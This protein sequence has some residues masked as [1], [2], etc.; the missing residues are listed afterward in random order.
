MTSPPLDFSEMDNEETD[1]DVM[2]YTCSLRIDIL[3]IELAS[4][5]K[6]R[7]LLASS[8]SKHIEAA[9]D[10]DEDE[11]FGDKKSVDFS[12]LFDEVERMESEIAEEQNKLQKEL[13][14][15]QANDHGFILNS[16][17]QAAV[18]EIMQA[19]DKRL[20]IVSQHVDVMTEKLERI[21]QEKLEAVEEAKS[22]RAKRIRDKF[23][24]LYLDL[25]RVIDDTQNTDAEIPEYLEKASSLL[26][27]LAD[28]DVD[29]DEKFRVFLAHWNAR[30][31]KSVQALAVYQEQGVLGSLNAMV[32]SFSLSS[33]LA[34]TDEENREL[35][36]RVNECVD[37]AYACLER[38]D[39]LE[40]VDAFHDACDEHWLVREVKN[41]ANALRDRIISTLDEEL[42][43]EEAFESFKDA[44]QSLLGRTDQ[45]RS[46]IQDAELEIHHD[47][48]D[49]ESL[50]LEMVENW[51][52]D[53]HKEITD[54]SSA[55]DEVDEK[56]QAKK[57]ALEQAEKIA[58]LQAIIAKLQEQL[59]RSAEY[60]DNL[61]RQL[62][63][64]RRSV[65][66]SS[67]GAAMMPRMMPIDMSIEVEY[68][69]LVAAAAAVSDAETHS[70]ALRTEIDDLKD[71]LAAAGAELDEVRASPRPDDAALEALK[72][73][74]AELSMHLFESDARGSELQA[75]IG[76]REDDIVRLTREREEALER[77]RVFDEELGRERFAKAEALAEERRLK[78]LADAALAHAAAEA[79]EA[80]GIAAEALAERAAAAAILRAELEAV[81]LRAAEEER[82]R[83]A[84]EAERD[85]IRAEAEEA[86]RAA[87]A[88]AAE[89]RARED[90]AAAR[91]LELEARLADAVA[92]AAEADRIRDEE[93][94][95]AAEAE[96]LRLEAEARAAE[97]RRLRL[98]AEARA[99]AERL[100]RVA[101]E[102]RARL[103]EAAQR[104]AENRALL[105][106]QERDRAIAE[107]ERLRLALAALEAQRRAEAEAAA[108]AAEEARLREEDLKAQN[109]VLEKEKTRLEKI[110]AGFQNMFRIKQG[111][112]V[113]A[114]LNDDPVDADEAKELLLKLSLWELEGKLTERGMI[115]NLDKAL[116]SGGKKF[117]KWS[118][119]EKRLPS[120][121]VDSMRKDWLRK[122]SQKLSI[123]STEGVLG[124]KEISEEVKSFYS[125]IDDTQTLLDDT[126]L[127]V[128]K[129]KSIFASKN[130]PQDLRVNY[131]AKCADQI[132]K[133]DNAN[134][135]WKHR[136]GIMSKE[137]TENRDK[138]KR[139]DN[140]AR[141]DSLLK[142]LLM[143]VE[144]WK[145][146][147]KDSPDDTL[148]NWAKR[149]NL[150]A[151]LLQDFGITIHFD[152]HKDEL[153]EMDRKSFNRKDPA[154]F[155]KLTEQVVHEVEERIATCITADLAKEIYPVFPLAEDKI[156]VRPIHLPN[157][158]TKI[159][160]Y[161]ASTDT[162]VRFV[163]YC[164]DGID[165][166]DPVV[167]KAIKQAKAQLSLELMLSILYRYVDK[168][169]SWP[170]T[171]DNPVYIYPS[172]PES[173]QHLAGALLSLG[174]PY[175]AIKVDLK[176]A[177][178]INLKYHYVERPEYSFSLEHSHIKAVIHDRVKED[179][180]I[181]WNSKTVRK[182]VEDFSGGR[183]KN[184]N[185]EDSLK[186]K[187]KELN[188]FVK[189]KK[190]F[191]HGGVG[192]LKKAAVESKKAVYTPNS[193]R[194]NKIPGH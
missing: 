6:S 102:D 106:E 188:Q 22:N 100:A 191:M 174:V 119:L 113:A 176:D 42:L 135:A 192:A 20:D 88:L 93:R 58:R 73:Q 130:C 128:D 86:A 172:D 27:K 105:A 91:I 173:L 101:A 180:L 140:V 145:E 146:I 81:G 83:L 37:A 72:L 66:W 87:E 11:S 131:E 132:T 57:I 65:E 160:A 159:I 55:L 12:V 103:A 161:A 59:E 165:E 123:D 70:V 120:A 147:T 170:P 19:V 98:E 149:V 18:D 166:N 41:K 183:N 60:T 45:V 127:L 163:P 49:I 94:E 77:A 136:Y 96:R 43:S 23:N 151:V 175:E 185:K 133:W 112:T 125:N 177:K 50:T 144:S 1:E 156:R 164:V 190:D 122:M 76:E 5:K 181:N 24:E 124:L 107:Q 109:A 62:E 111:L 63:E 168:S 48:R 52:V 3:K 121:I 35:T 4:L 108:I 150:Q 99:N 34:N 30:V 115:R 116:G 21:E 47:D 178:G 14:I 141:K 71:R 13:E 51:I 171:A 95:R 40:D 25:Q 7:A 78:D 67:M 9:E 139:L 61:Q 53:W 33:M 104:A 75:R 167:Q 64:Q 68:R 184:P 85:R 2:P 56:V 8:L 26:T 193:P 80:A 152:A 148:A 90:V 143:E 126:A 69:S 54:I 17:E 129:A 82:A 92:R 36:D 97:E 179:T 189:D 154:V 74:V 138:N 38:I 117:M 28:A 46:A 187:R 158:P 84:A 31:N 16:S 182:F 15:V 39:D 79:A 137:I 153:Y 157:Y 186:D 29:A 155:R 142:D 32:D 44:Y 110:I 89:V 162:D 118:T 10:F 169:G 134:R 194:E 114:G